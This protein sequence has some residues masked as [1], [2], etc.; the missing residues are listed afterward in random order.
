MTSNSDLEAI[1]VGHNNATAVIDYKNSQ[2]INVAFSG[3]NSVSLLAEGDSWYDYPWKDILSELEDRYNYDIESVSHR[4]DRI[5]SMAYNRG[6]LAKLLGKLLKMIRLGRPPEAVLLSGGGNDIA[7]EQ[8]S[9]I[10]NN[11][12]SSNP[13]IN[14]DVLAGYI[15]R[16]RLSYITIITAITDLCISELGK[17]IPIVVHG[18]DYA[19]PDG[20]GYW[21]GWGPFPGPW[22]SP[23][24]IEKGYSNPD[25]MQDII[26]VIINT[27]NEMLSSL[28]HIEG[29]DHTVH[30][31][32]RGTL[33]N[34]KISYK[35][36]WDN[37]L[38][39]TQAG[40]S[41]IADIFSHE[42]LRII[43]R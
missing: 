11:A 6:Q 12:N 41:T 18:Y 13:G 5:E 15:S 24:F 16:I 4:G 2:E 27:F 31:D 36:W 30:I 19:V 40:F 7:G 21:G 3:E 22:L 8:F 9:P 17:K 38:H 42:I 43:G 1:S 39:P 34:S 23:G 10:L 25:Q 33:D 37:E 32:L 29:M 14:G 20:R 26:N 35:E 28:V